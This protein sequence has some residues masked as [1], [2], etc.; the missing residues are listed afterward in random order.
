[1]HNLL[2]LGKDLLMGSAEEPPW[3]PRLQKVGLGNPGSDE[4]LVMLVFTIILQASFALSDSIQPITP[5]QKY[6]VCVFVS[7]F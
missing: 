3:C 5:L 6:N 4:L 2:G 7:F 1:M